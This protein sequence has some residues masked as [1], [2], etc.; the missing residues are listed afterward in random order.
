[1]DEV[2]EVVVVELGTNPD[3]DP[4]GFAEVAAT[5]VAALRDRGAERIAWLTRC[6]AR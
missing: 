1:M 3:A 6:T 5:L 4:D 2:P